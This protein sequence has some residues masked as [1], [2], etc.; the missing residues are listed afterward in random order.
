MPIS[1]PFVAAVLF[2]TSQTN[3]GTTCELS[4][5]YH[6]FH[7]DQS[8]CYVLEGIDFSCSVSGPT[9]F[10]AAAVVGGVNLYADAQEPA[11]GQTY[12]SW[13]GSIPL[14]YP[15]SFPGLWLDCRLQTSVSGAL[16]ITAWGHLYA[17]PIIQGTH[18]P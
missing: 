10:L 7:P 3:S 4:Q 1:T 5:D 11:L 16:G 17:V 14:V 6:Y 18:T 13:R 9:T 15:N 2:G 8:I 12:S